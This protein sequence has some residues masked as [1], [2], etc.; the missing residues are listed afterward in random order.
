MLIVFFGGMG[1]GLE[2][3]MY[4]MLIF[5]FRMVLM[6]IVEKKVY[7]WGRLWM[8]ICWVNIVFV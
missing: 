6:F 5:F 7:D 4:G 3:V 8:L 2:G 1:I